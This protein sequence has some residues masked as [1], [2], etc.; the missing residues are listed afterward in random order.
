MFSR[1]VE[2]FGRR[3]D[4]FFGISTSGNSPNVIHATERANELGLIT[5]GLLGRD[6][7]KMKNLVL[8]PLIVNSEDT[9]AI[10][11]VHL[12]LIHMICEALETEHKSE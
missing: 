9:G 8:H 7:G 11:E 1:Q 3:G 2:A 5:V 6:G 12:I 10:Q 4:V